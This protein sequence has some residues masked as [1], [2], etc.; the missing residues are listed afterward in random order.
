[1]TSDSDFRR[2]L[3]LLNPTNKSWRENRNVGTTA[4]LKLACLWRVWNTETIGPCYWF[5]SKNFPL[6]HVD[7]DTYKFMASYHACDILSKC[8][9]VV[10][11]AT[12]PWVYIIPLLGQR[13]EFLVCTYVLKDRPPAGVMTDPLFGTN[14]WEKLSC[15]TCLKTSCLAPITKLNHTWLSSSQVW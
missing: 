11:V 9:A 5:K 10:S 2:C 4:S 3:C 15:D 8:L 1:M 7:L 14:I 13:P 6:L 12:L